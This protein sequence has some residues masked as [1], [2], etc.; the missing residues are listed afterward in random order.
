MVSAVTVDLPCELNVFGLKQDGLEDMIGRL[1][2]QQHNWTKENEKLAFADVFMC[3]NLLDLK[4]KCRFQ[5]N[6]NLK[7]LGTH[8]HS[9]HLSPSMRTALLIVFRTSNNELKFRCPNSCIRYN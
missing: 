7:L 9:S 1:L 5:D 6:Q 8:P 4:Y 2:R 3:V